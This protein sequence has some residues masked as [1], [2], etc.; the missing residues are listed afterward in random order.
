MCI[1]KWGRKRIPLHYLSRT[2]VGTK[3]TYSPIEK[4][5]LSLI[6]S[7]QRLKHY[8]QAYAVQMVSKADPIK[9]IITEK[10]AVSNENY[11]SLNFIF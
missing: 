9:Y 2:L 7:I 3:L 11:S 4:I 1:G 8:M 10:R 5:C 6:F